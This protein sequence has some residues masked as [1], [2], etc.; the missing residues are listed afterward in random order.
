MGN[1]EKIAEKISQ[2]S[3]FSRCEKCKQYQLIQNCTNLIYVT[4]LTYFRKNQEFFPFSSIYYSFQRKARKV[5]LSQKV[6]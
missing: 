1:D 3:L 6:T 5:S 4:T 2:F